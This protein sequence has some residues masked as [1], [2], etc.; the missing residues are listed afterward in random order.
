[1]A[2]YMADF[3]T[4]T[5]PANCHVW[6][7]AVCDI[8]DPKRVM[9]GSTI[10]SFMQFCKESPT[11]DKVYFHNLKFDGQFIIQWLFSSGYK[12][13]HESSERATGTFKTLITDK[14]L[15]YTIEVIFYL[16]GKRVNKVT[17]IDSMKLIPLSVEKIVEAF[18]LPIQKLNIDYSAH[19]DLPIGSE[20]SAEEK[21]YI[22]HDVQIVAHALKYFFDQGLDR[23]TIGSCALNEYKSLIKADK[24]KL[25]FP[26]PNYHEDVRQSYRGGFTYLNPRY[27]GKVVKNGIVLDVN[28]LYPYVMYDSELPYGTPIFFKGKYKPDKIYPLYTQMIRCSFRIKPGKIPTI[29]MKNSLYFKSTEYLES[30]DDEEVALC[31]NSVDLELFLEHY[32]VFNLEYVSGW[33][34]QGARGLFKDYVEKWTKVKIEAKKAGNHG[35]YLI[36]KLFLNSLYG[37]FGTDTKMR[38]KIPDLVEG[39]VKYYDSEPE[40]KDGVY[41]AMASFITSYARKITISSAQKIQDDYRSG[42]SKIEF[43]YADTDSLHCI[44]PDFEI[45]EGLRIHDTDLGAWKFESKFRR[46]KFLRQKCYIEEST[47]DIS[48]ADPEYKLKITVSGMPESCHD[49]V[50]FSN[51]KVGARYYGK[52]QPQLVA[53]GVVLKDVDF[54]IKK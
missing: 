16:K 44:S 37:K 39:V 38:F 20:I 7:Y 18:K 54:T 5:D 14:G 8:E 12:H 22:R 9:I 19:N 48:A 34:F 24:F 32:D 35:L 45:P 47:E 53:G 36:A 27:S 52:L 2:V 49:Q 10:D 21:E 30:S 31:L 6:A 15:Y 17:F 50:N 4:T 40:Q 23:L 25:Y 46:A 33:K 42:K 26:P 43:V 51:F 3:E 1:M 28:S 11:N 29:Q 13:V 41:I